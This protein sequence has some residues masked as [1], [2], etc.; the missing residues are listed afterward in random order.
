MITFNEES[1]KEFVESVVESLTAK[2]EKIL[3]EELTL[4]AKAIEVAAKL[5]M[6][7]GEECDN[8]EDGV[9]CED[10]PDRD[11][12][13]GATNEGIKQILQALLEDFP[14]EDEEED[15]DVEG[16]N[17]DDA[18]DA[19]DDGVPSV[20]ITTKNL[21]P[22]QTALVEKF[23]KDLEELGKQKSSKDKGK[24]TTK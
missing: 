4:T 14:I 9:S 13:P 24:S 18:E 11:E 22:A 19:E 20:D 8:A 21:N 17:E 23:L 10:C 3:K 5:A 12:C 15:E 1:R 6:G 2:I 16:G 7:E